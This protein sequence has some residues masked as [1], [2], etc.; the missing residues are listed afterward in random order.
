MTSG[1]ALVVL[2]HLKPGWLPDWLPV[3]FEIV[4]FYDVDQSHLTESNL[5]PSPYYRSR[6]HH[7]RKAL[8]SAP[9]R[10][11]TRLVLLDL[12]LHDFG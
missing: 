10:F 11:K 1:A 5:R 2:L 3:P 9:Y 7:E 8:V 6:G 12:G 4:R